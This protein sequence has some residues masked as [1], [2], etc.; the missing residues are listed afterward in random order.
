MGKGGGSAKTPKEQPDNLKSSQELSIIDLLCEGQIEGPVGGLKGVYLNDTP[1]KNEDDSNN[2]SGVTAQWLSGAQDQPCL[3]GFPS[4]ENEVPVSLEVKHGTPLVRTITDPDIDRVR[5]TLGTAGLFEQNS[6]GDVYETSVDLD[7]QIGTGSNW[8]TAQTVT[9]SG[10]TRSQYLRSIFLT[11]LPKVPFN[12]RVT[13]VTADSTSSQLENKTLWSSYTEI[14]DAKLSYPNTAL[15]GLRFDSTQFQGVPKRNYLVRGL[16]L[17]V[18]SNYTPETRTYSGIW[19]GTFKIAWSNNP[20]WIFY[21]LVMND[22]YGLGKRIGSFGCDKWTMYVIGQYCDQII[23]D[24]FGG[25]EPRMTC[26]CYITDRRQAYDLIN[27]LTSVFRAMPVWDG[28]QMTCIQ[29]RPADPIWR[30]TNANVAD[31]EFTYQSSA[32]KARH[33]AIHVRY[34]DP[35]NGWETATEYVADD[36][37]IARYGLNVSEID[38]FGCTSR[39]QAYRTG[40]WVLETERLEKQSVSFKVGREG[41][42]HLPGDIIEIAD[43]NYAGSRIGGRIEDVEDNVITLDREVSIS[44]GQQAFL[45]YIDEEGKPA[46][47]SIISQSAPNKVLVSAV[48]GLEPW[49]IWTLSTA[50]IKPRL[51]RALSIAE[52]DDGTYSI[53]A[54]QHVPEKEAA[55]EN[56][57][58]F[59]PKP[60]TTHQGSLPPVE[61]LI[62]EPTPESEKIQARAHWTTPTVNLRVSFDVKLMRKGAIVLRENTS[63][64]EFLLSGLEMDDYQLSVRCRSND[65]RL[66]EETIVDFTMNPPA[67]PAYIETTSGVG[68]ITLRPHFSGTVPFSTLFE[69]WFAEKELASGQIESMATKLVTSSYFIHDRLKHGKTYYYYVRSVNAY[70]KSVFIS[71]SAET[72]SDAGEILDVIAGEVVSSE[73]GK[74]LLEDVSKVNEN[75][76][77]AATAIIHNAL[78]NDLEGKRWRTQFGDT[79]ASI[80]NVREII[81]DGEQATAIV[82]QELNSKTDKTNATLVDL[83]QTVAKKDEA[84]ALTVTQLK[85]QIDKAESTVNSLQKTVADN[86]SASALSIEQLDAKYK[87]NSGKITSTNQTVANNNAVMVSKVDALSTSVGNGLKEVKSEINVTKQS[88]NELNGKVSASYNIKVGVT[89]NGVKYAAGMGIGV[90]NTPSGMQSQVLF[91]ADRFAFLDLKSGSKA[92]PFAIDSGQTFINDAFIKAGSITSAKIADASI[93]N[94]KIVNGSINSAKIENAAITS[95][96][97]GDAQ[98]GTLKIGENAVII[99]S[100]FSWK[101]GKQGGTGIFEAVRGTANYPYATTVIIICALRQSYANSNTH[102][103]AYINVDGK[104]VADFGAGVANDSPVMMCSLRLPAGQHTFT[105]EWI[106]YGGGVLLGSVN[107]AVWGAMR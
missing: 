58:K 27:D 52:N 60:G 14:I 50:S 56:G 41:I 83:A 6:N 31:G 57:I 101:D 46:R 85:S 45:G 48:K 22:R 76:H 43:N 97:I 12:I 5:V 37:M 100:V 87:E 98:I 34:I 19:D 105:A 23:D 28:L 80:L 40:R 102:T 47:V 16:M 51:F 92:V 75:V 66:G 103:A 1:V 86:E 39:G 69:F 9:I 25:K 63:D 89:N 24:G 10:K 35:D 30:Y 95:A 13:R 33:T 78:A 79:E 93:T 96:K 91:T 90:E 70:G 68:R 54:L 26:N 17:K 7:V 18:P 77:E 107:M 106:G 73:L 84:I 65:G 8:Q 3:E 94:A 11:H 55:I 88:I 20:A 53:N 2:F 42:K 71:T 36:D 32:Q 38:A 49:S 67:P 81:A 61:H 64:T 59:E 44:T 29:D 72:S 82:M 74:T 4:T 15:V 104:R 21:D 62:I 99:P